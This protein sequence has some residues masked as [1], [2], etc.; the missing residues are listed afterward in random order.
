[1]YFYHIS[2]YHQFFLFFRKYLICLNATIHLTITG[3]Q[4]LCGL[5]KAPIEQLHIVNYATI[6]LIF[7]IWEEVRSPAIQKGK[8][9][10]IR[11]FPG[12]QFPYHFLQKRNKRCY[13]SY[14]VGF[15]SRVMPTCSVLIFTCTAWEAVYLV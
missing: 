11:E 4:S 7:V 5:K 14:C 2:C 13:G 6:H 15:R 3:R 1:M 10:M 8:S 9:K 12:S